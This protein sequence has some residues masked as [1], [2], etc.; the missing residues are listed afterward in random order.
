MR[1]EA[2]QVALP[3]A[4]SRFS[5]MHLLDRIDHWRVRRPNAS[6]TAA[7]T[8][9]LPTVNW[10]RV[11]MRSP[12][13]SR[14]GSAKIA[15]RS[16]CTGTR[17]RRCCRFP[18]GGEERAGRT[19]RSTCRFPRSAWSGS[20]RMPAPALVLTPAEV[21]ELSRPEREAPGGLAAASGG[22]GSVLHSFYLGQHG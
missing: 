20:S 4:P 11:R 6:P 5:R 18:G 10:R 2:V 21:A 12:P 3:A 13:C 8:A 16:R 17:S 9:L 1:P 15:R 14:R 19:C 22:G 7:A